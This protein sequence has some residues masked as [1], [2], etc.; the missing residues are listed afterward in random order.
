MRAEKQLARTQVAADHSGSAA[1]DAAHQECGGLAQ[2]FEQEPPKY[3]ASYGGLREASEL[4][5]LEAQ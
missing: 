4:L 2:V 5:P 1:E 3:T